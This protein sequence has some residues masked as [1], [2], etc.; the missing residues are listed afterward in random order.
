MG[1]SAFPHPLRPYGRR[2]LLGSGNLAAAEPKGK[3]AEEW[4][5]ALGEGSL[6]GEHPDF[7]TGSAGS[8]SRAMGEFSEDPCTGPH[9]FHMQNCVL[10]KLEPFLCSDAD[11]ACSG[12][13]APTHSLPHCLVG[14]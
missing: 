3:G 1:V 6:E 5:P 2:L 11:V 8:A 13:S 10:W 7:Q 14:L 12:D 4:K 9:H